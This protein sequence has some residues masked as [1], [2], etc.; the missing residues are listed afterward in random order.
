[1]LMARNGYGFLIVLFVALTAWI[2]WRA[3]EPNP[4]PYDPEGNFVHAYPWQYPALMF[5][6]GLLVIGLLSF[7]KP[8]WSFVG[9]TLAFCV[10]TALFTMLALTLMHSPP[11][12]G[13]LFFTTFFCGAGLLFVSGY[14]CAVW[15]S[16]TP[17]ST[18]TA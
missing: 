8:L 7:R 2:A 11:V 5:V 1:M 17:E 3:T 10:T 14:T 18:D 16:E 13:S 15:R 4:Y 9:A 6:L 12:H